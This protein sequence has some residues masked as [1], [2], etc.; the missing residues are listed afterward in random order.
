M[1]K[2]VLAEVCLDE[3]RLIDLKTNVQETLVDVGYIENY[4]QSPRINFGRLHFV[5]CVLELLRSDHMGKVE[6]Q[7]GG[8][9]SQKKQDIINACQ[10]GLS[11]KDWEEAQHPYKRID[12][13][14]I[15]SFNLRSL[16]IHDIPPSP[17]L[18]LT[19]RVAVA[20]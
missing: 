12:D 6:E 13:D 10:S 16:G 11:A 9:L 14:D 5:R 1:A 2:G 8:E 20:A 15:G 18:N 7:V 4:V 19:R 3:N 17:L